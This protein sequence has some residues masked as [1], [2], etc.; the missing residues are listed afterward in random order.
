MIEK[1]GLSETETT[2]IAEVMIGTIF[3]SKT[4]LKQTED[5]VEILNEIANSSTK[6]ITPKNLAAILFVFDKSDDKPL[7]EFLETM[8][9]V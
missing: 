2:D 9:K 5:F 7:E 3:P 8:S 4:D 1:K 6:K